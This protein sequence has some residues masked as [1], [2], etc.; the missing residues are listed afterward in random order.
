MYLCVHDSD[1]T[2]HIHMYTHTHIHLLQLDTSELQTIE[3]PELFERLI[4][5]AFDM[6]G[7]KPTSDEKTTERMY[8]YKRVQVLMNTLCRCMLCVH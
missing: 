1:G 2:T 7:A 8:K 3:A 4:K 5:K 6:T